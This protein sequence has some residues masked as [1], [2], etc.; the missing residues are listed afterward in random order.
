MSGLPLQLVDPFRQ[1]SLGAEYEGEF[2]LE[3]MPRLRDLLVGEPGGS[4]RYRLRF[5]QPGSRRHRLEGELETTVALPCQRCFRPS[6]HEVETQFA[7]ELVE[8]EAELG[9]LDETQ[10]GLLVENERISLPQ[11]LEDEILLALPAI[12]VHA[13]VSEC[14]GSDWQQWMDA[15]QAK[16]VVENGEQQENPFAALAGLKGELKPGDD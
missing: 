13:D 1:A 8:S 6:R 16:D 9:L 11:L 12:A 2:P 10:E 14:R 15:E 7:F 3:R 4:L 5:S